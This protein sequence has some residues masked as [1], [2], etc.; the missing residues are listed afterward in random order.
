MSSD[1][2]ILATVTDAFGG[3]GGIAQYNRHLLHAL[4]RDARVGTI[5]VLPR[6]V[7]DATG[8]VPGKIEF[9]TSSAGGWLRYAVALLRRLIGRESFDMVIC[10]HIN[11]LPLAALAALRYRAPLVLVVYGVEVWQRPRRRI[12]NWLLRSVDAICSISATTRDRMQSWYPR[13]L[14]P[15][16]LLPNAFDPQV[17]QPGPKPEFLVRR[18]GLAQRPTLLIFG[19]MSPT[20][21]LKGFDETL[22]ATSD[23][24]LRIPDLMVILAGDGLDRPRLEQK[25]ASLGIEKH[26]IFTG[27]V[28]EHE[29]ADLYRL[30]DVFILPSQQEGFGF[31]LIEAMACG[32]PS[33]GSRADGSREAVRDGQLGSLVDPTSR[34]DIVRVVC[35][36]MTQPRRI[37][38]GLNYFS[39]DRFEQR[40]SEALSLLVRRR[41]PAN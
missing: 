6:L 2:R 18:Y 19:R 38:D 30:A 15:T 24:L 4:C 26:V 11:L 12:N 16:V 8:P 23:L 25:A 37:P 3:R 36:A 29:K 32:I 5:V 7:P 20:E 34:A 13:M 21:R 31:V 41:S 17:F 28:P 35:D 33:I 22:E 39:L 9:T 1:L 10:G 40:V 27:L 14:P